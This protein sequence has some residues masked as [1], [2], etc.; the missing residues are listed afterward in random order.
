MDRGDLR[1]ALF[2]A[3]V[4]RGRS[5]SLRA[6]VRGWTVDTAPVLAEPVACAA[7]A[8]LMADFVRDLPV[9]LVTG[10]ERAGGPLATKM[11]EVLGGDRPTDCRA[12][13]WPKRKSARSTEN[14]ESIEAATRAGSS[15]IIVDDIVN[16]GRTVRRVIGQVES[17]GARV[18]A[19]VC[20]VKYSP[21]RPPLLRS[22]RG[23]VHAVYSLEDLGLRRFGVMTSPLG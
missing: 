17:L 11:A 20:L 10:I 7:A 13:T 14:R 1:D 12:T 2:A 18:V 21:N 9:D 4:V 22:W 19:V 16:S 6:L 15:T 8:R 3:A 23:P 5:G